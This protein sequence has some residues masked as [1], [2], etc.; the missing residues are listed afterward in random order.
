M[1]GQSAITKRDAVHI[2]TKNAP[3]I[4]KTHNAVKEI[5]TSGGIFFL[6]LTTTTATIE[7]AKA[8]KINNISFDITSFGIKD[9][10]L[11]I[12][13]SPSSEGIPRMPT[14]SCPP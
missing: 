13:Y 8:P 4:P 3:A 11:T 6:F 12:L 7:K 10:S 2:K 9:N 1:Y 5:Q 14:V